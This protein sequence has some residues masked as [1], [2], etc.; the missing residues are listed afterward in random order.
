MLGALC[1][2]FRMNSP[3]ENH[4]RS[5][6]LVGS[7][8]QCTFCYDQ[9]LLKQITLD[10]HTAKTHTTNKGEFA[11]QREQCDRE[12]GAEDCKTNGLDESFLI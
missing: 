9:L 11:I 10:V 5:S 6:G 12:V 2:L 7:V 1:I 8:Q 4:A 3:A